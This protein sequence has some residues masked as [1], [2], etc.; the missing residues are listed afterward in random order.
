VPSTFF[1]LV[2]ESLARSSE[3]EVLGARQAGEGWSWTAGGVLAREILELSSGLVVYGVH[4]GDRVAVLSASAREAWA[5]ELAVLGCGA[6]CVPLEAS[7]EEPA[8]RRALVESSVRVA[9]VGS[10]DGLRRLLSVRPD[11]P[12]LDLVL[13]LG[14][15]PELG[16]LPATLGATAR[17]L[18][19]A[20]LAAD[21][22]LLARTRSSVDGRREAY[23]VSSVGGDEDRP[24][25]LGHDNLIAASRALIEAFPLHAD[26]LA[27][28]L[29]PVHRIAGRPWWGALLVSGAR[30]AFADRE[31]AADQLREVQPTLGL[32][33]GPSLDRLLRQLLRTVLGRSMAARFV[34]P[35]ARRLGL[36][37]A[38]A[39]L[40]ENRLDPRRTWSSGLADR[41][42]LERVR[43]A[44]GGRLRF[45]VSVDRPL[46]ARRVRSCLGLGLPVLEGVGTSAS[47]GV[48]CQN[49]PQAFRPGTV[50]RPLPGTTLKID[51]DRGIWARGP[52]VE[53]GMAPE[54]AT[55]PDRTWLRTGLT[56]F[57]DTDGFVHVI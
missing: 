20:A 57:Q 54:I 51:G 45:F 49:T 23:V 43:E 9:M 53:Q 4:P 28:S 16:A 55:S 1:D 15:P 32:A 19:A 11:L 56:G 46:G 47:T 41:L 52:I 13:L 3:R 25:V 21:P 5:S 24:I 40:A 38:R 42:I 27:V 6:C 33:D 14:E 17:S 36:R 37:A 31:A 7:L 34:L 18:G 29:V 12:E 2:F 22:Q 35:W 39:G 44:A 50:G 48:L 26:D 8:L 10:V 30:V